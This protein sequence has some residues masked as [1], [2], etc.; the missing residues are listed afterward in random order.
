MS[1]TTPAAVLAAEQA[2][3]AEDPRVTQALEE[4]LDA[5]EAGQPPDR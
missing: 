4:Y 3:P 2:A 1:E 5:L